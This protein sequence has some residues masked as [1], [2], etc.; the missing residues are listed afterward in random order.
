MVIPVDVLEDR[1]LFDLKVMHN[2]H[3][4]ARTALANKKKTAAGL[5]ASPLGNGSTSPLGASVS[6]RHYGQGGRRGKPRAGQSEQSEQLRGLTA[7]LLAVHEGLLAAEPL[8][9]SLQT[10]A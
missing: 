8:L 2:P 7:S 6:S 4:R 3:V 1:S 5:L 9:D 10:P